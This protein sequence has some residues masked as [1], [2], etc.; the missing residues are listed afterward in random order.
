M[1]KFLFTILFAVAVF[2]IAGENLIGSATI[3]QPTVG[4]LSDGG[5]FD[6]GIIQVGVIP[7]P[8]GS[9]MTIQ[10]G[11]ANP[12]DCEIMIAA[13]PDAGLFD[14]GLTWYQEPRKMLPT[15][16][17]SGETAVLFRIAGVPDGGSTEVKVFSR[18]GNE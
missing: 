16:T 17:R 18:V 12:Q 10:V 13:L 8:Q 14:A 7:V 6:A 4:T 2:A 1:K 11:G 9:L 5:T 15:S 3:G